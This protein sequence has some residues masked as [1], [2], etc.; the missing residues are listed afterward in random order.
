MESVAHQLVEAL[1]KSMAITPNRRF[2]IHLRSALTFAVLLV[3]L[4]VQWPGSVGLHSAGVLG[5]PIASPKIMG[6]EFA[7]KGRY[8]YAA[9]L[10]VAPLGRKGHVW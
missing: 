9:N 1:E 6:G 2:R 5:G 4:Y 7:P 8:L 10:I 3:G